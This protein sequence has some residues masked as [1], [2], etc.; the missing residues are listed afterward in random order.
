MAQVDE[1][2]SIDIHIGRNRAS[3]NAAEVPRLY[4]RDA[5]RYIQL[6]AD[7]IP[8]EGSI[9]RPGGDPSLPWGFQR[10][11]EQVEEGH[12]S[13]VAALPP[14]HDGK[15]RGYSIMACRSE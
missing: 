15:Y 12:Q 13:L 11:N 10:A 8:A 9:R 1:D 5:G 4:G 3:H 14:V 7:A 2:G 6:F